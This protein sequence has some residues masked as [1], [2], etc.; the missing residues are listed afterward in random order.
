MD[1]EFVACYNRCGE[2]HAL[3]RPLREDNKKETTLGLVFIYY[4]D[5]ADAIVIMTLE[6]ATK[7]E[8]RR[9]L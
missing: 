1:N 5:A 7:K 4:A 9:P 2:G 6:E 3:S 8:R